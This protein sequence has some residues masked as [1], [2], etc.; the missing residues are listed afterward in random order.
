MRKSR[1]FISCIGYDYIA[2][3]QIK[4]RL[5]KVGLEV[6]F[7]D[8]GEN[9]N[10]RLTYAVSPDDYVILLMS[11]FY[12]IGNES[13]DQWIDLHRIVKEFHY[14]DVNL[15][16][17][18]LSKMRKSSILNKF[19]GFNLYNDF[20]ENLDKLVSYL[21]NV[22]NLDFEEINGLE[23]QL[24]IIDLLK[25]LK[26]KIEEVKQRS[27][28]FDI[29]ILARSIHKNPLVGS[30]TTNWIIECK[31]HK[32]NRLDVSAIRE[33]TYLISAQFP[34]HKGILITNG[35]ITSSAREALEILGEKEKVSVY[36][37]DGGQLK[38]LLLK[39]PDI[40]NKY[41]SPNKED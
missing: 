30:F 31:L 24:L 34:N 32:T 13:N 14:R 4:E 25:K 9:F 37:V 23:F 18:Y 21:E 11:D 29:D 20:E 8:R 40:I 27:K 1:V 35:V 5:E 2:A 38:Q 3:E 12:R 22:N 17:V 15:I 16:P 36:I 26:F 41:F 10:N 19:K 28:N 39:Y 6:F 33:F 7:I